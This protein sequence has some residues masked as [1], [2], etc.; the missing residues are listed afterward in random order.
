MSCDGPQITGCQRPVAVP[1]FKLLS[2]DPHRCCC[3]SVT[4]ADYRT[5]CCQVALPSSNH[6][7]WPAASL[8]AYAA[9]WV[10]SYSSDLRRRQKKDLLSG[11]STSGRSEVT[12]KASCRV[13]MTAWEAEHVEWTGLAW[14]R[15]K[16]SR[17]V[18]LLS[19]VTKCCCKGSSFT[20]HSVL[21]QKTCTKNPYTVTPL[22]TIHCCVCVD[23]ILCIYWM[24]GN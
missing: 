4:L 20:Q 6:L 23:M 22:V 24:D 21:K 8:S 17:W 2:A 18:S 7:P 9:W 19:S 3:V 13:S 14:R 10:A 1:S 15:R 16:R 5:R 12:L 11:V